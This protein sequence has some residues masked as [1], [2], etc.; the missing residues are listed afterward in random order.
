[1]T[2]GNEAFTAREGTTKEESTTMTDMTPE[3]WLAIRKEAGR[4]LDPAT[5]EIDWSHGY[6]CDPYGVNPDLPD[7]MKQVGRQYWARSPG[8]DVWVND[9]DWPK[10]I[11]AQLWRR[12]EE[13]GM[14]LTVGKARAAGA[15]FRAGEIERGAEILWGDK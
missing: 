3:Q 2:S 4:K 14:I 8:S 9:Q 7:E 1:M 15:A 13:G 12:V 11:A 5:A 10:E 6:D